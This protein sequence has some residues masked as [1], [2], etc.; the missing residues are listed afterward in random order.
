MIGSGEVLPYCRGEDL[1][2]LNFYSWVFF[3]F[4]LLCHVSPFPLYGLIWHRCQLFL[5]VKIN[6]LPMLFAAWERGSQQASAQ[7]QSQQTNPPSAGCRL[8]GGRLLS[9]PGL[10]KLLGTGIEARAEQIIRHR[11]TC[12]FPSYG[13]R[14][15]NSFAGFS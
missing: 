1:S 15:G 6:L 5:L 4:L 13:K 14:M 12:S 11:P 10:S 7:A 9:Q 8:L 2:P 3:F